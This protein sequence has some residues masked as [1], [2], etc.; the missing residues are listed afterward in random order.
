[1]NRKTQDS[2]KNT[3]IKQKIEKKKHRNKRWIEPQ[4]KHRNWMRDID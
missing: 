1:M 2:N 4:E 3:S